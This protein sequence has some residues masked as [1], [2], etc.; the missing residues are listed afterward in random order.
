M[1]KF[2]KLKTRTILEKCSEIV[3]FQ[4]ENFAIHLRIT[5]KGSL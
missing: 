4:A 3:P 2:L 1:Y 5:M